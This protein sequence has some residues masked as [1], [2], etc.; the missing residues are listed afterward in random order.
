MKRVQEVTAVDFGREVL[1]SPTPVVVDVFAAWCGPC[2]ALAPLLE[3]YAELYSGEVKFVKVNLDA[4]P[5]VAE[6]YRVE[7][8]P[9]LLVFQTGELIDRVTGIPPTQLMLTKL[10]DLTR[11]TGNRRYS[12]PTGCCG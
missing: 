4:E 8:V 2:R 1:F 12:R 5:E 10:D 9:T 6:V 7:A 11:R 3:K